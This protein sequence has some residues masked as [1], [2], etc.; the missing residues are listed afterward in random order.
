[1]S[2]VLRWIVPGLA[3][4]I[5]TVALLHPSRSAPAP[6]GSDRHR[7]LWIDAETLAS[8]PTRGPAWENLRDAADR[9]CGPVDVTD[10]S[11]SNNT[12]VLAK[13]LVSARTGDEA[14]RRDVVRAL[15]SLV[16][17]DP[18]HGRALALGRNLAAYVIAADLIGLEHRDPELDVRFR[19]TLEALRVTPTWGAA[20]DLIDCHERRPNNWGTHCGASRAAIAL[21]LGDTEDLGRTAVVFRGFLGDRAS[22]DGFTFG[23]PYGDRDHSWECDQESPVGIN[24]RGCTRNG[25]TIDGVIPDDQRRSGPF[26][27]PPPK[28]NYAWEALQGILVQAVLLHRAGFPT[29]EWGDR[30]ILRA[31]T[32]LHDVA[33]FP[34]E[35]DDTWQPHLL[36]HYLGTSFPAPVPS[37]PGKNMGWTDWTHAAPLPAPPRVP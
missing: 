21:Y 36:N 31:A 20:D 9:P 27:W 18:Y 13:A 26:T 33:D 35:G 23:G 7:A 16:T 1:M 17:A 15:V 6:E 34:A 25:R 28:E 12:C 10:Q 2:P 14:L 19:A 24:P 3:A 11:S 32:W 8:L 29:F 30:A 22:Y 4:G 37:R 5:L